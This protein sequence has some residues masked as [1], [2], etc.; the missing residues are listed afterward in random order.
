[1]GMYDAIQGLLE[2]PYCGNEAFVSFQTKGLSVTMEEFTAGGKILGGPY[3]NGEYGRHW[4]KCE[5]CGRE[6]LPVAVI[7]DQIITGLKAYRRGELPTCDHLPEDVI[8]VD[9]L[10]LEPPKLCRL[11]VANLVGLMI[12]ERTVIEQGRF[13]Y[14]YIIGSGYNPE[15]D[16]L[17]YDLPGRQVARL[18][19]YIRLLFNLPNPEES[20]N[21]C[22]AQLVQE[23]LNM[24]LERLRVCYPILCE[25]NIGSLR[26]TL[27]P[28]L[29]V[30]REILHQFAAIWVARNKKG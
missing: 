21:A 5:K 26:E 12:D 6:F 24:E 18:Y 13:N 15:T 19:D 3:L 4:L 9:P 1:M 23:N 27:S 14:Q 20:V 11:I 29:P 17:Q 8:F 30:A 16:R 22:L 25:M 28:A 7:R 2:C 10:S